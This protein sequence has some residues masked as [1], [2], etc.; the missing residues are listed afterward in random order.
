MERRGGARI[1][2]RYVGH[3]VRGRGPSRLSPSMCHLG[4][5]CG[6]TCRV[7]GGDLSQRRGRG[8]MLSCSHPYS[9]FGVA[10]TRIGRRGLFRAQMDVLARP[11]SA[12]PPK[13]H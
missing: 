10:S 11:A 13:G 6:V 2:R 4:L 9:T 3:V 12:P 8:A 7:A 5:S 1:D